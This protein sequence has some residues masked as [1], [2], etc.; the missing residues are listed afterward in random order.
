MQLLKILVV[1]DVEDF[2]RLVCS[3]LESRDEFL[4][5]LASD[6]LVAV[7]KAEAL[8]PDL[9]LLDI[10]LPKLNGMEVARRVRKLAP[11]ARI[12]FFSVESDT[13][14]VR[15]ALSLG[16]G[17][18]HK[19][20]V[21]SDLLSA[22]EVVLRGERFVSGD[23]GPSRTTDTP[24]RHEVQFYS[25]DSVLLESFARSIAAALETGNAAIVVATRSRR[26]NLAQRLK[27][28]G[29][30]VDGATQQ[31]TYISLDAVEMLLTIMASGVPDLMRF[32]ESLCRVIGS[33]AQATKKEHPRIAICNEC[34]GLLC[35]LGNTEA[36]IRLEKVGNFLV[37][38]RNVDILC[39][40]PSSSF[41]GSEDSRLLKRVCSEHT[42]IYSR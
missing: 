26:E 3:L 31:G 34:V 2:R 1:E 27:A 6:G 5:E 8:Q 22:I 14:L 15:E 28:E 30:D 29:F 19:G 33:A 13:D 12:I 37:Q 41:D 16:A 11:S 24:R 4:L 40:Y 21:Q 20:R 7:R 39:A 9:I 42:F 25:D 10:S 32:Y 38:E 23:L 36:A 17:Y 35:A 18:I